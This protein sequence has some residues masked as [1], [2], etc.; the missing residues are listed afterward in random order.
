M[1]NFKIQN[2]LVYDEFS[3]KIMNFFFSFQKFFLRAFTWLYKFFISLKLAVFV[4][5][6]LA[7][8]TAV[9]S[10]VEARY[11][12]EWAN[13]LVYHSHWMFILMILLALNLTMVLVDR[14]PWKKR[15]IPFV[16]AHIGIL[17]MLLGSVFTKYFGIDG[18][19][20]FAEGETA[21]QLSVSEM[22]VKVYSSYDGENFRL[23]YE[24]SVD[25]LFIK[26]SEKKPYII[27]L[28]KEEFAIDDYIPFAVGREN[29]QAVSAGGSP[30]LRF[31]LSGSQA[32]VVEW[33]L[34]ERGEKSKRQAFGPAFITFTAEGDY[35]A[36]DEKELVLFV[37]ADKLFYSSG[38]KRKKSLKTGDVFSTN[39]MDFQFRLIEFFPRARREFLFEA[40]DRPS[41]VT[42]KALRVNYKG[43]RTWLGQNSYA[44]FFKEDQVYALAYL[45][46]TYPL[47]FDLKLVDFR[48]KKYQGSEKAKSYESL[49]RVEGKE[50]LI[51]MNEPL[52]YKGWTFYQSSF[53]AP[54]EGGEPVVSI[55]S[56]NKD[57]GRVLK[58]AGSVLIVLGVIL[59]FYR[60]RINKKAFTDPV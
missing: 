29:F 59:L 41:D 15:H 47:G 56:V 35:K 30:A 25:M 4:L 14:W 50:I 40:R 31:H 45:N 7:V 39:W 8:L 53:E 18:S 5:S 52:K 12:Q 2:S 1:K 6:A 57:P 34:L 10:F 48:I 19:L 36:Q 51:S 55:L 24:S 22:E 11:N 54:E 9:G 60:R 27:S 20:R 38:G 49:V 33:I 3:L 17:I 58:Y 21:N 23:L 16:L 32:D 43:E 44:R 28:G 37:Q 46:K 42:L 13:K 26:P